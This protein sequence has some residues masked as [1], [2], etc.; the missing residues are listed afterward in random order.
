MAEGKLP[1]LAWTTSNTI[2]GIKSGIEQTRP[3]KRWM[4]I[5]DEPLSLR[6]IVVIPISR[7]HVDEVNSVT[8]IW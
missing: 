4:V 8:F 5:L 2:A 1:A 7:P 3:V 6:I